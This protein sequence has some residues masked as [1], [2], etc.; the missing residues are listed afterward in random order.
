VNKI[1][2]MGFPHSGTTI[3]RKLIGNSP[4][5]HDVQLETVHIPNINIKEENVVIKFTTTDIDKYLGNYTDFKVVTIIKSPFDVFGSINR[6]FNGQDPENHT[7]PNW[8]KYA[9]GFIK[10][11]EKP[12]DNMYTVR[13]EDLFANSYE[14]VQNI[15]KFL[16]LEFNEDIITTKRDVHISPSCVHI[17]LE[18]P[19]NCRNGIPHGQY[20]TWQTNQPFK[21]KT[22][23]SRKY[24]SD[25]QEE[26]ISSLETTRKLN[27]E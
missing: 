1:V 12:V 8:D 25:R 19:K 2:V 16:D 5:V 23:E 10:Y 6:R 21:N 9:K 20:R 22:G 3:L 7:I 15:Y 17:P 27:Y 13:Y 26:I 11:R 24:L 4:E 14:E 18:E